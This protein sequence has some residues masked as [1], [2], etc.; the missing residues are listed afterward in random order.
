MEEW[1]AGDVLSCGE[2]KNMNTSIQQIRYFWFLLVTLGVQ[3]AFVRN[4]IS[5][6]LAAQGAPC[7]VKVVPMRTKSNRGRGQRHHTNV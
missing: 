1:G 6:M 3:W 5:E 2:K 4:W 7:A